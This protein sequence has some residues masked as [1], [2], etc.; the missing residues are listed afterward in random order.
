MKLSSIENDTYC[1]KDCKTVPSSMSIIYFLLHY[2]SSQ[3]S[4][5]YSEK[6]CINP[7]F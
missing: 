6:K 7:I 4:N 2:A 1:R 3:L 5:D